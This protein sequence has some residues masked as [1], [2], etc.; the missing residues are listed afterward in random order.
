MLMVSAKF[1]LTNHG[2]GDG[3]GGD[4]AAKLTWRMRVKGERQ[5]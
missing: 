4:S 5:I 3:N 2:G 1:E